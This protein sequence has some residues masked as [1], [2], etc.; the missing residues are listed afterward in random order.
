MSKLFKLKE[1]L[2]IPATARHL[3]H[4][5]DDVVEE[6]DILQMALDGH[7]RL[8]VN[9]PNRAKAKLG[10][11][12]PYKDVPRRELPDLDGKGVKK[13]AAGYLL[14]E[15]MD[16]SLIN[17]D[18]PFI[19]FDDAVVSIDGTWDL[20]MMANERI[21]IEYELHQI[22]GGPCVTMTNLEGTFLNRPDGT[23]ASLQ[24]RFEDQKYIDKGGK[25]NTIKGEY[26]PAG[27]LGNDCIKVVRTT[28]LTALQAKI[29]GRTENKPLGNR[30]RN[31]MLRTIAGLLL[32]LESTGM[33]EAQTIKWLHDQGYKDGY[34]GLSKSKLEERFAEAKRIMRE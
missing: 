12:I 7:L 18:T 19:C 20:A 13:Y 28:E 33:S 10:R 31:S 25:S 30:E 1:W 22:I 16:V 24:D 14:D 6:A 34:E 17:E 5:L 21:D 32:V 29:D 26:F 11:V 8:S 23:W 9:F 4:L 27:G 3:S 2:T 15:K